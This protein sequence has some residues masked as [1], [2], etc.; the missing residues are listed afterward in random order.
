VG[1][2]ADLNERKSPT[3]YKR[4][5]GP[6]SRSERK[7]D[8]INTLSLSEMKVWPSSPS[9]YTLSYP[10]ITLIILTLINGRVSSSHYMTSFGKIISD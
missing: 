1:P 8:E 4:P 9:L 2:R 6:Q 10:A 7:P 3:W 5:G